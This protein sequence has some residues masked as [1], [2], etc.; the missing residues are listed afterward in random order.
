MA[1]ALLLAG[2]AQQIIRDD[3][4]QK[5]GTGQ[6]ESAIAGLEDGLSR[7]PDSVTLRAGLVTARAEAAARLVAQAS[8]ER[9]EGKLDNAD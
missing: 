9:A 6:Y 4:T 2:C 5:L 1:V 7:Y 3:A 8:Q